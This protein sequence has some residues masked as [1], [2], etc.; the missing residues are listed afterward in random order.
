MKGEGLISLHKI[1]TG[2]GKDSGEG[3][4]SPPLALL[5]PSLPLAFSQPPISLLGLREVG[6]SSFLSHL[7]SLC[8]N[9]STTYLVNDDDSS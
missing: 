4:Q 6:L 1:R 8:V 9:L 2:Q 5:L 3:P 7:P